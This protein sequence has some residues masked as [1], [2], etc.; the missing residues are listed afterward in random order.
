MHTPS[1][2]PYLLGEYSK[3]HTV[4][5]DPQQI[6]VL[7]AEI[8]VKLDILKTFKETLAKVEPRVN[9]PH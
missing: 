4:P 6:R 3:F 7:F 9:H 1:G 5:M 2:H 8:N